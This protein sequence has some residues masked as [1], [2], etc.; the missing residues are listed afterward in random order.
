M[1]VVATREIRV[2]FLYF[3]NGEPNITPAMFPI[4]LSVPNRL[5]NIEALRTYLPKGSYG[6][7]SNMW[8]ASG[9]SDTTPYQ[10]NGLD[11][12][13]V[14]PEM[15]EVPLVI[16]IPPFALHFRI[17]GRDQPTNLQIVVTDPHSQLEDLY[18]EIKKK[19]HSA[20]GKELPPR[21][22]AKL[23]PE[24]GTWETNTFHLFNR[25][26][27]IGLSKGKPMEFTVPPER[28]HFK[29]NGHNIAVKHINPEDDLSAL[30]PELDEKYRAFKC[31]ELPAMH[32]LTFERSDIGWEETSIYQL[33]SMED[34][35]GISKTTPLMLSDS[36]LNPTE[37]EESL[38]NDAVLQELV[39]FA[40]ANE[41][42]LALEF[43]SADCLN[44]PNYTEGRYQKPV[45]LDNL[46]YNSVELPDSLLSWIPL[47]VKHL[48][49]AICDIMNRDNPIPTTVDDSF[50]KVVA[51][52][53]QVHEELP[54]YN[55]TNYG[56]QNENFSLVLRLS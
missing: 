22:Y 15:Q 13:V 16:G 6:Q 3:K 41:N 44:G 5:K 23:S 40:S 10:R 46:M 45:L 9:D 50:K 26:D 8:W 29:I 17:N 54:V 18:E 12:A 14:I 31:G 48:K 21:T 52:Y 27:G 56:A 38:L 33:W 55:G 2:R 42:N 53:Q 39:H 43:S 4:V 34:K 1:D 7:M 36:E 32:L 51:G 37:E 35:P 25:E 47:D 19:Y 28:W 20:T 30:Y 24:H 49:E 11:D